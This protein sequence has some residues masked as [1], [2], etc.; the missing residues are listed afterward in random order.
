MLAASSGVPPEIVDLVELLVPQLL[1]GNGSVM[2]NL[3]NQMAHARISRV[4]MTGVG[5]FLHFDV[6]SDLPLADPPRFAGGNA[7]IAIAGLR[8]PAGCVLFVR[9][10]K[11]T[12]LELYC[13]EESW[14]NDFRLIG[15]DHVLP[16]RVPS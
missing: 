12:M 9:D 16:L 4:D 14:P 6:P 1:A 2:V 8:I 5:M 3:R 11:L 10:G 7:Q 15:I 13:F